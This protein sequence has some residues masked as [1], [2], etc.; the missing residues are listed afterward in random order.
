[1]SEVKATMN[2]WKQQKEMTLV[3][4]GKCILLSTSIIEP[5]YICDNREYGYPTEDFFPG[6]YAVRLSCYRTPELSCELPGVHSNLNNIV[7]KCQEWGQR[8]GGDKQRDKP[9]LDH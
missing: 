1:M 8:E 7:D 2:A 9:K 4:L 6:S 3:E 5:T